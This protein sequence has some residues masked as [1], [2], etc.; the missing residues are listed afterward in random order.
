MISATDALRLPSA[1]LTGEE[2][3]AADSL[4][5]KIESGIRAAMERRG[6]DLQTNETRGNVI[7]EINQRL[8]AAGWVV[9][10]RA[11]VEPP[12]VGLTPTLVGYD[13]S[14]APS[15]EAYRAAAARGAA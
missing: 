2:A 9:Q 6:I 15:D 13:L 1:Q 11:R 14:L 12:R 4:E 3:A 8:K 5:A 7:A 10:W